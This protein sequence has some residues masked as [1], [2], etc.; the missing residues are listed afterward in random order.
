MSILNFFNSLSNSD[1]VFYG[2]II[3]LSII[4]VILFY[5]IYT[6]NKEMSKKMMEKSVF[7]ESDRVV[8]KEEMVKQPITIN[9]VEALDTKTELVQ[10]VEMD[11][12]DP[13]ELTRSLQLNDSIEDLQSLTKEL[14]TIP[15]ERTIK[16][17]PYEAEQEE[18]AIIS[19]DELVKQNDKPQEI[20]LLPADEVDAAVAQVDNNLEVPFVEEVTITEDVPVKEEKIIDDIV[21]TVYSHEEGFLK[22]LKSLQNSMREND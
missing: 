21:D 12:P 1:V 19:Y 15:R 10:P 18:T 4:S 13:L 7:S 16:M 14:E 6:Q 11:I 20:E 22:S 17:T 2:L 9:E 3:L 8:N 5:L